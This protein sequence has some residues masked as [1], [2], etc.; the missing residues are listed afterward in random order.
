MFTYR[1]N[2]NRGAEVAGANPIPSRIGFE[3]ETLMMG[4]SAKQTLALRGN[5]DSRYRGFQPGRPVVPEE[6]QSQ[7]RSDILLGGS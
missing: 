4:L 3:R 6:G 1:I 5:L 7:Y 2:R